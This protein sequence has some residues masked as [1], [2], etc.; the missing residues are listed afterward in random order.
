MS[1][2]D[3]ETNPCQM[4]KHVLCLFVSTMIHGTPMCVS[5]GYAQSNPAFR[6]VH[7]FQSFQAFLKHE[8]VHSTSL[9]LIQ[10]AMKWEIKQYQT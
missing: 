10:H 9:K 8:D 7:A 3:I 5:I 4:A 1:N 6:R 2:W